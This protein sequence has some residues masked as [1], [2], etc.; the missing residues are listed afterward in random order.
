MPQSHP[1]LLGKS[2]GLVLCAAKVFYPLFHMDQDGEVPNVLSAPA[3][4]AA[5]NFVKV[6]CQQADL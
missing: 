3:M 2:C 6:A 1:V 5:I 4:S